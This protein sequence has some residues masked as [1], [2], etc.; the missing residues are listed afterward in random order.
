M[1]A[2]KKFPRLF[3]LMG[4]VL[5]GLTG[6][7]GEASEVPTPFQITPTMPT[8]TQAAPTAA[9]TTTA[10]ARLVFDGPFWLGRGKIRAAEFLPVAQRVVIAWGSGV[11]LHVVETGE[12]IWFTPTPANL[13]AFA[14]QPQAQHFAAAL[15]NGS[16]VVFAAETGESQIFSGAKPNAYWGDL[17]WS[18]DGQTI[19]FQFIGDKR[20]DPIFLLDLNSGQI[21]E[22]PGSQTGSHVMPEL[23]WSPDGRS[24]TVAALGEECSR[25]IDMDS[26]DFRMSLGQPGECYP[27]PP[28][29]FLADGQTLAV[30]APSG[31]V[32]LIRFPEGTLL[33]TLKSGGGLVGRQMEFPAAG[34]TLF[35]DPDGKYIAARGGYEPCYCGNP[36]D[37]PY[38]PLIVWDLKAGSIQAQL[39]R[40]VEPLTE[41]HRLAATFDG[42][43]IL[44]LYDS[45]AITRWPFSD[46]QAE[47]SI[48]AQI[49]VRPVP[50]WSIR[51]SADG[52]RLAFTGEYGGVDVY[53]TVARQLIRRFD[54]PLESPALN[55]DGR[56]IA[57]YD[58]DQ[59]AEMIFE[60]QSGEPMRILP[61]S[62]VLLGA[63]F[64]PD[65]QYLA[66]GNSAKAAVVEVSSG[67]VEI[68]NP[69]PAAPVD[70][71][72]AV[73][74]LIWSPDG[75]AL[76]TVFGIASGESL[77]AGVIVLWQRQA[78]HTFRAVYH[79]P[80][81]QAN[82]SSPNQI[83]AVFNP[84]GSRI[85]LRS[86]A[87]ME[88]G[89]SS[90]VV[91]DLRAGQVLRT[92]SEYK[93]AVWFS[94]DL[95]LAAEVQYY[96]RLVDINVVDGKVSTYSGVDIGDS[97]YHPSGRY[98]A[99]M[100][101]PPQRGV[102]I[103]DSRTNKV[104]ASLEHESLNLL[105][106][107]WSPDGRW[108]VS[109]GD[110]GTLRLW[111]IAGQ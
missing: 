53:D 23:V 59:D 105:D 18:P 92:F 60:L 106:Y 71:N 24:I 20:S 10:P 85:A 39:E 31:G 13:I 61:G 67:E 28:L 27:L 43:S 40:A 37:Q 91:F 4:I 63:A 111:N 17:A 102:T 8:A 54:P 51:W 29:L 62:P 75:Q 19:A 22:V 101:N 89:Q 69:G 7:A 110:D 48:I 107:A 93:P 41:R 38:H 52:S 99:R 14:V 58:P 30:N 49:P 33:L 36:S 83:L 80:N 88:A 15:S 55:V 90:L 103:R 50:A 56:L 26:G 46:P 97:A 5:G 96:T 1:S 109:V 12:K 2:L 81:V 47:E 95:L 84:S 64:S 35:T 87:A 11:S 82:Y 68:L 74:R 98:V 76:V 57:L 66:Y 65:G 79:V 94:D 32:D 108:L 70:E 100:T 34:G 77:E 44:A 6:C 9:P 45:G 72:M 73:S 104:V 42:G 3:I 78:N 21:R 86:L 16:V 25:F